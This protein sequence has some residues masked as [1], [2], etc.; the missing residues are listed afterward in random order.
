MRV[1]HLE[2]QQLAWMIRTHP[3]RFST[4]YPP[5]VIRNV[6]YDS[7]R[8]GCYHHH[9]NGVPD[10]K[11]IRIR[12]YGEPQHDLVTPR[13]EVKSK[14]G[15]LIGKRHWPLRPVSPNL[16]CNAP[17]MA[18]VA[19]DLGCPPI[20]IEWLRTLEPTLI[21]RY[22]REYYISGD[23][24]VRVTVDTELSYARPSTGRLPSLDA[25]FDSALIVEIKFDDMHVAQ[26]AAVTSQFRLPLEKNSKYITGMQ[27]LGGHGC[28][29]PG[30][31]SAGIQTAAD[32]RVLQIASQ[33]RDEVTELWQ[34][35]AIHSQPDGA[36]RAGQREHCG[37]VAH[38]GHGA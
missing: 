16:L 20:V 19:N 4:L 3:A 2:Q 23:G 8:L 32:R 33:K 21:N 30:Q 35:Q 1:T 29:T 17:A 22:R 7:P 10:R 15:P 24:K 12:S 27:L 25:Y 14:R 31:W 38:T 18:A 9:L 26:G 36:D 28:H 11:K 34:D 37:P 13:V 6:Y 5:R